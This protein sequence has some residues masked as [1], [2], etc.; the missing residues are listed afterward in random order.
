MNGIRLTNEEA[1][2]RI[3]ERCNDL[4]YIFLGFD[5]EDNVYTNN[6]VKLKLHCNKCGSEWNTT[7][8]E[9]FMSGRNGCPGCNTRRKQGEK[10]IIKRIKE[11]CKELN[12]RFI[13]FV[14]K[15][16]SKKETRIRLKCKKCKYEWDTTTVSNFLR[17]DRNSHRCWRKNPENMPCNLNAKIA[18][19][20]IMNRLSG[21]SLEFVSFNN[22]EYLGVG[23]TKVLL[24][25]KECGEYST[26]SM[27]NLLYS[28]T[29][30]PQ[31]IKCQY[32]GK[33]SNEKAIEKIKH[34]C[35]LL[36]YEFLGFDN[37]QNRYDGKETRLILKCLKCGY[38]WNTTIYENFINRTI[39]CRGCTNNWHLERTVECYLKDA[40]ISYEIQKRFEWLKNKIN[41]T[42]DFYLPD[43][44][45]GI[46][47]QGRQH[48]IPVDKFGG[49][50]GFKDTQIRDALKKN[51][52]ENHKIKILYFTELKKYNNFMGETL[53]KTKDKL[54]ESIEKYGRK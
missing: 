46:E 35:K 48:F 36:D 51:Q 10:E 6:K 38:T 39:K 9:K 43:Y 18:Q 50:E 30:I 4:N 19:N 44:D 28:T 32:N 47:C 42:L 52:C 14:G 22:N 37:P 12:Y 45:I 7:S 54:V 15:Y 33:V 20:K 41:M 31:C 34:K 40:G 11:R 29:V 49:E 25:C 23:K 17:E 1:I 3:N 21:S 5:N 26:V 8:Y 24:K 27:H 13:G 2:T 53:V 16:T